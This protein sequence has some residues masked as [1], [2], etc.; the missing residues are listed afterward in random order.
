[1]S[2]VCRAKDTIVLTNGEN[3]EPSPIEDEICRSPLIKFAILIGNGKR[4]LGALIVPDVDHISAELQNENLS[5]ED[6]YQSVLEAVRNS[7]APGRQPWE[8][9]QAIEV[10][11]T[12]FSFEDGTLTRTM[13]PRRPNIF[14][15]Y[16]DS[17]ER[18]ENQLR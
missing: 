17:I 18:L 10:L 16:S 9:V 15:K 12:E 7:Q 2:R 6:I 11:D 1:M 4:S 14:E 3:V 5:K 13:K 8:R